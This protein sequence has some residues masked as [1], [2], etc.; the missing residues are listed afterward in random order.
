MCSVGLELSVGHHNPEC[1]FYLAIRTVL[2]NTTE[3]PKTK[4]H[5]LIV[6][7]NPLAFHA[8]IFTLMVSTSNH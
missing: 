3:N 1:E 8:I 5:Q 4:N 6:K 2:D 7:N